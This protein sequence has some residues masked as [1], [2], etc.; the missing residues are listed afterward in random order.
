M[1]DLPNPRPW[2]QGLDRLTD[3]SPYA[4]DVVT[5]YPGLLSELRAAGRLDTATTAGELV[6]L[7]AGSL[8]GP[9]RYNRAKLHRN[10]HFPQPTA[11]AW[12]LSRTCAAGHF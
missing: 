11:K 5:R 3:L 7:L 2:Q 6:A 8:S 10:S 12:S 1:T 9:K 4:A